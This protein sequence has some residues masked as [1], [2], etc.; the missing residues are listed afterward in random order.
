LQAEKAFMVARGIVRAARENL[1]TQQIKLK[2]VRDH[3]DRVSRED[4]RYLELATQEHKL[5]QE[6][7]RL[8]TAYVNAEESERE[9]FSLFSAAVRNSHEKERS[10]AERTKN[11]SIIG[12]VLGAVIGVLGSTYI[13]RV[14]LQEL[15]G[16][17]LEA[18]KG[19]VSLQ[20]AI[21]QQASVHHSQQQELN[22]LVVHLRGML[23][24]GTREPVPGAQGKAPVGGGVAVGGKADPLSAALEEQLSLS[25]LA[26][27]GIGGLQE[28]MQGLEKTL[29]KVAAEVQGVKA[30]VQAGPLAQRPAQ[31]FT[32]ESVLLGLAETEQRLEAQIG[33]HAHFTT[34]F[35][36]A[37]FA[38]TLPVLY[39]IFRGN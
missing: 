8:R 6:E 15:R 24:D 26:S 1:E 30:V 37:A 27:S 38:L 33:K 23:H 18:Q 36:Y 16:L 29:G 14:R 11:W 17:L 2:E 7:R 20:E 25:K 4:I 9:A 35:T 31:V 3:Q 34:V 10:R 19:P 21:Q 22:N 32:S 12:S 28:K 39:F 13:N 5:L